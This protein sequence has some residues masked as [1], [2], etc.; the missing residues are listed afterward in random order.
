MRTER[1]KPGTAYVCDARRFGGDRQLCPLHEAAEDL[2]E[3][4]AAL[5]SSPAMVDND[6]PLMAKARALAG[7]VVRVSAPADDIPSAPIPEALVDVLRELCNP[8]RI[9][10]STWD[11]ARAMLARIEEGQ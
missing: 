6:E 11:R 8:E 9:R 2:L 10:P 5:V 7:K 1:H 3:V 4:V